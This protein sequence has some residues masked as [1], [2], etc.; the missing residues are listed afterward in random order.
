[1]HGKDFL[2]NDGRYRQAIEAI[3][4]RL[5]KLDVIPSLAFIVEAV[6]PVNRRA[7]VVATQHKKVFRILDLIREKKA[8]G[9]ERLLATVHIIPEKE[10]ICFRRESAIFKQA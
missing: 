10:V 6:D 8:D 2:I 1:M 3:G 5:P 7:F 4:K 9:L